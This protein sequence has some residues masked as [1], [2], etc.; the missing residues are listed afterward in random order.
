MLNADK[1]GRPH[2][3]K[4][5]TDR[6]SEWICLLLFRFGRLTIGATP[7]PAFLKVL[8]FDLDLTLNG[9]CQCSGVNDSRHADEGFFATNEFQSVP[10]TL[11]A[12]GL[13][14]RLRG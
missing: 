5:S 9:K 8:D 1:A 2:L 10:E 14:G 13:L 7:P 3:F 11:E 6:E 4:G 12:A